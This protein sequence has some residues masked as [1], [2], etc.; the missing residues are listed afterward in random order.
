MKDIAYFLQERMNVVEKRS[1]VLTGQYFIV[2]NM[3][4]IN[5]DKISKYSCFFPDRTV[6]SAGSIVRASDD[7]IL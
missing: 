6:I 1:E 7:E 3:S 2:D 5:W 4:C